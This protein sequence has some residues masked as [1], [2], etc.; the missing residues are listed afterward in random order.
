MLEHPYFC[1]QGSSQWRL[2]AR[3]NA[4]VQPQTQAVYLAEPCSV[5]E[6]DTMFGRRVGT[7]EAFDEFCMSFFD[8]RSGTAFVQSGFNMISLFFPFSVN[9]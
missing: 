2:F 7:H 5:Q 6:N 4:D 3:K 8:T 1:P 9:S